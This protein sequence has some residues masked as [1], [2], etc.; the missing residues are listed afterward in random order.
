MQL[1]NRF[2]VGVKIIA[3]YVIALT[4]MVVVG[5]VAIV[6]LNEVGDTV[7]DVTDD[8]ALDRQLGND[9]VAEILLTRY[10]ANKYTATQNQNLLDRYTE[11]LSNLEQILAV[12]ETA[13]TSSARPRKPVFTAVAP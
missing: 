12:A 3:G 8:L 11:E 1:F 10:Y 5:V 7:S 13:I 2:S 6:R 9:V 4:L